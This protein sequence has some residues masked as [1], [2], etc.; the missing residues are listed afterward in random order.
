MPQTKKHILCVDD[1]SDTCDLVSA[2]LKEYEVTSAYSMADAVKRATA[3]KFDLY[4]LDYHLPDGTGLELCLMLRTFDHDT[5]ILFATATSSITEPQV[6]TAG[7]QG[8]M[9]KGRPSFVDDLPAR[10]SQLLR[11]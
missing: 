1:N 8:L 5:P 3:E 11:V 10:V 9:Q 2:I 4:L 7:A 6:I